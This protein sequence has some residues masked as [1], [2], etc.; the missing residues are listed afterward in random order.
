MPARDPTRLGVLQLAAAYR[1]GTL[2]PVRVTEAYL[3]RLEVGPV[4]RVVCRERA[5][6]QAR[7]AARR[8]ESGSAAGPLEGVPIAIKDLVDTEGEV[9]GACSPPLMDGPPAPA[10]A[11]VAQRLDAAGAVFL[12]KT[13][14][15]ELAF[16]GL[17][18]NPHVGTPPN[19]FRPTRIPGGSSSGSAVAVAR[20]LAAAALGSDTGGSVRIPAAFNGLVGLKTSDGWIPTAGTAP[21]STTLD[22]LG[23]IARDVDDAWALLQAMAGEAPRPL[24]T[25]PERWRL[26]AP[27][28][29]LWEDLDDGVAAVC[30]AA[31]AAL[32]GAG[33]AVDRHPSPELAALDGLFGRFGS[34][35]AF[36]A[37][38]RYGAL[39]ERC[40]ARM[41]PRVTTRILA[42]RER[43]ASDYRHLVAERERLRAAFWGAAAP[44]DAVVSPTVRVPPPELAP[45]LAGAGAAGAGD[46]A[47][48][49]AN[50]AVLRA[51]TLFNLLGGPAATV[52]AGHDAD[53][54][55]VGL[56]LAT[57]PFTDAVALALA[58]QAQRTL[59]VRR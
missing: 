22:T 39:I 10:D 4:Y 25:P 11:P 31:L 24:P 17:G 5:R 53:G 46:R 30:E 32:E 18:I 33:H 14:M 8:L 21:L 15:T 27:R 45:L 34:F 2:D 1:S 43:P 36:E 12:G 48:V 26:W 19:A 38:A 59:E 16:S 49:A 9:T 41:D 13:T 44:Y 23:P 29:V 28:T 54:L 47:Y 51:T 35:A 42:V 50:A 3:E 20:H 55:P 52:P 37:L 6:S 58:K 40:G 7:A 56:S 57:R